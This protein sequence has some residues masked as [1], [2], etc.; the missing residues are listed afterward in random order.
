MRSLL[1]IGLITA[2]AC[3][4]TAQTLV[5]D[6]TYGSYALGGFQ[7]TFEDLDVD[8][9]DR[10][11]V[12]AGTQ[13]PPARTLSV[14]RVT[15]T[16]RV[17]STFADGGRFVIQIPGGPFYQFSWPTVRLDTDSEGGVLIA[18]N[19][20]TE[21]PLVSRV[22]AG[23][24][25]PDGTLDPS[26]PGGGIRLLDLPFSAEVQGIASTP[27]HTYLALSDVT[28]DRCV[29]A[30]FGADGEIDHAFGTDG[31]VGLPTGRPCSS[32]DVFPTPDEV[33]LLGQ[34]PG[35]PDS[36]L[37]AG[38]VGAFTHTGAVKGGFGEDGS[39]LLGFTG[40]PF[41]P[42]TLHRWGGRVVVGAFSGA[43]S[44]DAL[45]A[46][47][48]VV[49]SLTDEGAA[50]PT[51]NDGTGTY[52]VR[53]SV[54]PPNGLRVGLA[55]SADGSLVFSTSVRMRGTNLYGLLMGVFDGT[56]VRASQGGPDG[57]FYEQMSFDSFRSYTYT[58]A[59]IGSD[60]EG[61]LL[62]GGSQIRSG[63][64]F[65]GARLSRLDVRESVTG[66]PG[67]VLLAP[68]LTVS[69]N[70]ASSSARI[71]LTL[72]AP[73]VVSVRVVDV[74]GRI[75]AVLANGPL[76]AGPHALMLDAS[77]LPSGV[78]AVVAVV[79]AERQVM[80]MTVVR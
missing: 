15:K 35:D 38:I 8:G 72:D 27:E 56:G 2:A 19:V 67:P 28:G 16:G 13:F 36:L 75:V 11:V 70:P 74:L 21:A 41:H 1:L 77:A 44:A 7:V 60:S 57:L 58:G 20:V 33:F 80:R 78:Y 47:E 10:V 73:D 63:S 9:L 61:R 40:R 71:S 39:V 18:G 24:L 50:D 64:S 12:A 62:V 14:G 6:P 59:W 46:E 68:A 43:R 42:T 51:F 26:F 23:R 54:G 32:R 65:A 17:D 29:L 4:G 25:R 69:P 52:T 30:A 5:L 22:F 76:A 34:L 37:T 31:L 45:S 48:V 66:L 53:P 49:V 79:G 55:T 3:P